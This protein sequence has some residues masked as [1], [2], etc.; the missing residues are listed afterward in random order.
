MSQMSR[1]ELFEQIT[2]EIRASIA[3]AG[4]ADA[5]GLDVE[6]FFA[7]ELLFASAT[8]RAD[9]GSVLWRSSHAATPENTTIAELGAVGADLVARIAADAT[10]AAAVDGGAHD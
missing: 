9:D 2:A 3:A 4:A 10:L 1:A 6:V 5:A 7:D 8:R